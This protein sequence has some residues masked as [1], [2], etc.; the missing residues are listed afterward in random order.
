MIE[1][2]NNDTNQPETDSTDVI[3]PEPEQN[4]PIEVSGETAPTPY[5]DPFKQ[6]IESIPIPSQFSEDLINIQVIYYFSAYFVFLLILKRIFY[7]M[8]KPEP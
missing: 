5:S 8:K 3:V 4:E 7:L 1:L 6:L 2:E